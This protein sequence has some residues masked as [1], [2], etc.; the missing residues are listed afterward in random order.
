LKKGK[1]GVFEQYMN[2]K[3]LMMLLHQQSSGRIMRGEGAIT[4]KGKLFGRDR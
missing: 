4:F 1:S 2:K 3:A